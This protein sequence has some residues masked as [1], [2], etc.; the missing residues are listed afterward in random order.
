M[1]YFNSFCL[2]CLGTEQLIVLDFLA[3][4]LTLFA[5]TYS[6]M[7]SEHR[8]TCAELEALPVSIDTSSHNELK[9]ARGF[10]ERDLRPQSLWTKSTSLTCIPSDIVGK[11]A[12]S[13]SNDVA[14]DI[15]NLG[16]SSYDPI[17]VLRPS[18]MENNVQFFF[19]PPGHLQNAVPASRPFSKVRSLANV[20]EYVP[21]WPVALPKANSASSGSGLARQ[22]AQHF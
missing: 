3:I 4:L 13:S 18:D 20:S 11:G 12:S 9:H 8:A 2:L 16:N 15:D 7:Q 5:P 1:S 17:E 14:P 10:L 21:D 22:G 6:G 19:G